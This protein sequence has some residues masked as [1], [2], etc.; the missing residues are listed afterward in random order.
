MTL[1]DLRKLQSEAINGVE[2]FDTLAFDEYRQQLL[3]SAPA[4]IACAEQL[5][6]MDVAYMRL[7][8]NGRDR[9][10]LLGGKCDPLDVMERNDVDLREARE[11]LRRLEQLT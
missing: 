2:V 1:D 8:E 3:R 7:L 10:L 9:I 5:K 4:L 6:K 11:A